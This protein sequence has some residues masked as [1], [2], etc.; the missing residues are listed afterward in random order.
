MK[1]VVKFLLIIA[2]GVEAGEL[3]EVFEKAKVD[4]YIRGTYQSHD[5]KNDSVYEDD[6]LGG[7]LHIETN[8]VAGMSAGASFYTSNALFNNE[9][10]GLVPLRGESHKSYSILGEAYLKAEFG[11]NILKVGRQEIET[12]FAQADDIGM[13]PN[14]FEAAIFESRAIRDVVVVLGQVQKMAGV[15]AESVDT[16]KKINGSKNVQVLGLSY[17]GI[18]GLT[19]AGWYY[20]LK[21]GEVD[22]IAYLEADYEKEM[23]EM[24]YGIGVQYSKQGHDVGDSATVYGGTVS[25]TANSFGLSLATAYTEVH[26]N[27]ATSGFGGGPFFSNS[28]YLI[29]DNAGKDGKATWFGAEYDAEIAG[30]KGVAF[31]LA[32]VTLEDEAGREAKE[33]DF[34]AS[35]EIN[36]ATEI[37]LI[38]SK[39]EGTNVG[40]DDAKHLRV[41][42]NYNF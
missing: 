37:H 16:F 25:A 6:A 18:S 31:G 24:T 4:G 32:Q 14:T 20:N 11:K 13:V 5:I 2:V 10:K 29:L 7:K 33:L 30:L 36:K 39:L 12:P 40:E 3:S 34:T 19:L 22:N 23:G 41:F 17:E 26:D 42:A 15:D 28:E 8:A 1:R 9:N 27:V 38:A 35:Y 21:D